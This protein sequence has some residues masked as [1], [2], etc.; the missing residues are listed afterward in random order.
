MIFLLEA[1][2]PKNKREVSLFGLT[3]WDKGQKLK[4]SFENMPKSFQVH[5]SGRDSDEAVVVDAVTSGGS[6]VIDIPDEMLIYDTDIL[7]WIYLTGDNSG[8]TIGKVT[9]YVKPRPRP[10]G[11]IEDLVPSGQKLVEIM[12]SELKSNLEHVIE[13]GVDSQYV[14]QYVK[15][16]ALRVAKEVLSVQNENTIS[17]ILAG[18]SHYDSS[19]YYNKKSIEHAGQ[20]MSLISSMCN[21]DFLAFLGDYIA[22]SSDKSISD[23]K[24]GILEVNKAIFSAFNGATQFRCVGGDDM[25]LKAYN[26]NGDYIKAHELYPLIGKWCCGEFNSDDETAGYCYKDF[27]KQKLRV[28]CLNTSDFKSDEI[29]K[30]E[31]NKAKMSQQQLLWFCDALSFV[32]KSD[33][34]DWSI[35]VLS[36]YPLNYYSKF[37]AAKEI[38]IAHDNGAKI[39]IVDSNGSE[40]SYDFSSKASRPVIA[41]FNGELHNLKINY[42]NELTLPIVSIPNICFENNNFYA[43]EEYLSNENLLYGEDITWNKT[44]GSE[45]D[46]AFCVVTIDKIKG[47]M[48]IHC[49]GAGYDRAIDF[50]SF[51]LPSDVP[52]PDNDK[53]NQDDNQTPENP[54]S[55][56]YTNLVLTSTDEEESLYNGCGYKNDCY[57]TSQG[58]ET[59]SDGFT[60]TGFIACQNTDVLQIKCGTWS[61]LVGN[62]LIV[63]DDTYAE[64]WSTTLSGKAAAS[65]GMSYNSNIAVFEPSNVITGELENMSYIRVSCKGKGEDMIVTAN[66]EIPIEITTPSVSD[67]VNIISM[68]VD[69]SGDAFNNGIGYKDGYALDRQGSEIAKSGFTVTGYFEADI[70]SVFRF[71]GCGWSQAQG[72][73]LMIYDDSFSLLQAIEIAD[74]TDDSENGISFSGEVMTFDSNSVSSCE[75]TELYYL[76]VSTQASG[77][78]LI[79]TYNEELS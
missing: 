41:M 65:A 21:M 73:Y 55:G 15:D 36:H 10:K 69:E 37:N 67:Y 31:T 53:D 68:S 9:L 70:G 63:Y 28:I 19:D 72:N 24:N 47:K 71:K 74:K 20:A 22:D 79:V 57:L 17:F 50:D 29:K 25:L 13:N 3:Q 35:I 44:A 54:D 23:A 61:D 43:G 32:D 26:R 78:D 45:K 66:E 56:N 46:T 62:N 5:F 38:L 48:Y 52:E 2:F 12:I 14:P 51:S 58:V 49:Y 8:E 30:G 27:T 1:I 11:Y 6:A 40:I 18:D 7:A 16:E 39:D 42:I 4:I 76:R 64:I 59:S 75:I 77:E 34:N 60:S 33:S